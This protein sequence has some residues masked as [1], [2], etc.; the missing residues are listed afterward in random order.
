MP[1]ICLVN[2][3]KHR[4]NSSE[5]IGRDTGQQCVHSPRK[6]VRRSESAY[7][8]RFPAAIVRRPELVSE[9]RMSQQAPLASA[10][11]NT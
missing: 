11:T 8:S 1:S 9:N 3:M 4:Q 6:Y 5:Y 7:E 2:D 10:G